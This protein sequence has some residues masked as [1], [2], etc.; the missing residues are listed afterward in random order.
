MGALMEAVPV[1]CRLNLAIVECEGTLNVGIGCTYPLE[2]D[3]MGFRVRND[4]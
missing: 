3:S 2:R 4:C 1:S